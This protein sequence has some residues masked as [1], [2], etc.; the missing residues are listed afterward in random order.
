MERTLN[1]PTIKPSIAQ[2]S[3]GMGT[4]VMRCKNL[5]IDV[6]QGD[7]QVTGLNSNNFANPHSVVAR[8]VNPV[9]SDA[10]FRSSDYIA[11]S[12]T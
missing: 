3:V 1:D 2:K 6:V 12:A 11:H 7:A 10:H 4:E 5:S 9:F 8:D